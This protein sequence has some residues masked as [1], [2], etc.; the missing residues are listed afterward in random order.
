[1]THFAFASA[2]GDLPSFLRHW[3]ASTTVMALENIARTTEFWA[4]ATSIYASY[5]LTQLQELAIRAAGRP[6]ARL[7]ELWA[8]QHTRAGERMYALCI[9]MRGFYLK[10]S[11]GGPVRLLRVCG[12]PDH[13]P[14]TGPGVPGPAGSNPMPPLPCAAHT[15]AGGA[16]PGG[17]RR[18]CTGADLPPA[19]A[20]ARPG[21][22]ATL[23]PLPPCHLC[24]QH[25]CQQHLCLRHNQLEVF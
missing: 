14:H 1:M 10:V 5:K 3:G 16:V 6:A 22:A 7:E 12:S 23:P 15:C 9:D 8:A 2:I 17:P 4:R 11:W 24:Q 18:L 21:P 13:P 25:L 20:T 19:V